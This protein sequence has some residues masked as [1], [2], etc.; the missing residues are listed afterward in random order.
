MKI[1]TPSHIANYFLKRA[2]SQGEFKLLKLVYIGYGWVLALT[3]RKLQI[4]MN[5]FNPDPIP[6]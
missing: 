1:Y 6:N 2:E 3:D 5:S 4:T